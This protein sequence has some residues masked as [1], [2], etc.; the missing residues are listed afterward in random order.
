M[1]QIKRLLSQR[2]KSIYWLAR[3]AGMS[4]QAIHA[5]ANSATIPTGTAWGT[6]QK[7]AAALGVSVD[8]LEQPEKG[9]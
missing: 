4:Y 7:V 2:G 1:N 9:E 8:E 6:L 3:Q 5:L